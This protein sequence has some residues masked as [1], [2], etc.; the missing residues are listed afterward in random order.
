LPPLSASPLERLAPPDDTLVPRPDSQLRLVTDWL[1]L[2]VTRTDGI[3]GSANGGL[4]LQLVDVCSFLPATSLPADMHTDGQRTSPDDHLLHFRDLCRQNP[5]CLAAAIT[6]RCE[7]RP[8]AP[9]I[10]LHAD[11]AAQ[12]AVMARGT[13]QTLNPFREWET[14]RTRSCRTAD[15]AIR[16]AEQ[17]GAGDCSSPAPDADRLPAD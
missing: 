5:T 14:G 9:I 12:A 7:Q 3:V 1:R 13:M 10:S 17:A 8:D 4:S 15:L 11:S 2:A 16:M 6:E